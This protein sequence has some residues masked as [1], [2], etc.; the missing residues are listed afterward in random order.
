MD[1]TF[2]PKDNGKPETKPRPYVH[3]TQVTR[4]L[5]LRFHV[6]PR[7]ISNNVLYLQIPLSPEIAHVLLHA[8]GDDE[9]PLL[10]M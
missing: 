10:R 7:H 5:A 2:V 4:V 1:N 6:R 3:K 9:T 8:F